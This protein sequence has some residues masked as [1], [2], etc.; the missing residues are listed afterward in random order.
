MVQQRGARAKRDGGPPPPGPG[1]AEEGAREP[2]WCKTPSG[3]IKRPMNAFMVWSQHE[4]RKIMDQWPDMHNAEISKRLGRRWQL[5]QDSEKIPFV[6]EAERL[7]LK[8]MADYPDYKYRPR[9]KSKGAP[10]KAR[11]R[12]PGGSGSGG[13]GSRLKPGPQ[14]PGRGSRRAAG[15]PLGGG[16]AAP[17][18]DDEDDDEELL[19]VRLVETPGRE[20]WRMVPAGRAARGPAERAQGP[21]GEGA[22]VTTASPT[23]SEDEEPEEEE[24]EA[25]AAEEGEEE[26]VA[27]GEEPLGFLSRLPPGPAGLDCSALDRDPDLPP[28]SGTSHFE[29]PDYCTPEVTEMIAGDWRPSSIA[30]LVFTY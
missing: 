19:E 5:L 18:D 7:R 21:S 14:L 10:A 27:S 29:F 26:T 8:H 6:R 4:R 15:G 11:P 9:K 30:D 20:L 12:P 28:P 1:T 22:A 2:G 17:E 16:A 23:P 3:H 24:E 13:G 25:A